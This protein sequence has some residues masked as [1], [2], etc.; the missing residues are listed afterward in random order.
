MSKITKQEVLDDISLLPDNYKTKDV[1]MLIRKYVKS[2]CD[3]S[4]L[5]DSV[6][7]QQQLHRIYFHGSLKQIANAEDRLKF[8]DENMLFSDWW[9]TDQLIDFVSDLDF[10][11]AYS[12]SRQY[13]YSEDAF[14]RRWGYVM[15]ISK[16]CRNK[17]NLQAIIDLFHNDDEY[18]VQMAQAWL[19]AEL[20]VF[21]PEDIYRYLSGSCELKYNI[22]GKAVQK[23]CDSFRVS[24]EW[25]EKFK[26][27]RSKLKKI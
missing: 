23:I 9:H 27:L 18:Y 16:L 25:K 1:D 24:D 11:K 12:Y 13:V 20:T 26:L 22:T 14:V 6:L 19:I 21:F 5:R 2:G 17:D 15:F 7:S 3:L 8:I 10:D 4:D